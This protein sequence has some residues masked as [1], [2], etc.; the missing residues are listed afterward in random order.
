MLC[1][2]SRRRM[3]FRNDRDQGGAM[4]GGAGLPSAPASQ[5]RAVVNADA[6]KGQSW[7][8]GSALTL[9]VMPFDRPSAHKVVAGFPP[10]RL[11]GWG[12]TNSPDR[13]E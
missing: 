12:T 9:Q 13:P 7:R 1:R 5:G 2:V 11:A 8:P 4:P 6:A 3:P 10:D